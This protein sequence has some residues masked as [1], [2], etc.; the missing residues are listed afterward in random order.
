[1]KVFRLN[2]LLDS[3]KNIK[4]VFNTFLVNFEE[5]LID[6]VN[7]MIR[8]VEL[9]EHVIVHPSENHLSYRSFQ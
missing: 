7:H 5:T 3:S 4:H 2:V 1:M 9:I 6:N 8:I